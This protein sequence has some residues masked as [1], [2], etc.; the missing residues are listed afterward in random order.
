MVERF[1]AIS[2]EMGDPQD[3]TDFDALME[4][5]GE[6][7]TKIDAVDGWSLDNQLEI[8]MEALRCPPGDSSVTNL[9]GGEKRR[10]ALCKLLLEKPDILLLDEPRSEEHTSE[11]QS[12]MRISYADFCLKK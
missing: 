3:D 7:Q 12:L 10:V 6:L 11:L 4:E 9:S 5:M 8:A 2:A 1:N